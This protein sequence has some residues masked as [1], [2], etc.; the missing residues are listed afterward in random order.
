LLLTVCLVSTRDF[1]YGLPLYQSSSELKAIP[2]TEPRV[3]ALVRNLIQ[4]LSSGKPLDGMT[5]DEA[6]AIREPF[7]SFGRLKSLEFVNREV[8]ATR[9]Y[10]YQLT[11]RD[12]MVF[13]TVDLGAEDKLEGLHFRSVEISHKNRLKIFNTVWET[14]NK[15]YFDPQFGGVDW[16][17]VRQRYAPR[18][19][20]AKSDEEFTTA[21]AEML[22]EL[23]RTSHLG[24]IGEDMGAA[25]SFPILRTGL[26]FRD[27]DN[28]VVITRILK[29]SPADRAGLR[30]GFT[31]KKI[32]D[33]AV[34][35]S[36]E[37][38][39]RLFAGKEIHKITFVDDHDASREVILQDQLPP[40]HTFEKQK[41]DRLTF[42]AVL[43]SQRLA[44]DIGYILHGLSSCLEKETSCHVGIHARHAWNHH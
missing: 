27:I 44:G 6:R 26:F 22:Q 36:G 29:D 34:G 32:D 23:P 24:I 31:I 33:A 37:T 42:Y 13:L 25:M 14:I 11:F 30:P 3:T 28:E 8:K 20:S 12:L 18:V 10:T 39:Q 41:W 19:T 5:E 16:A 4:K 1:A 43:E 38:L 21:M 15:E 9:N 2:D 35:N 7:A 17:A 40:A